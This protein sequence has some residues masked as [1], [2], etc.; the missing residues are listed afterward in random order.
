MVAMM[1]LYNMAVVALLAMTPLFLMTVHGLSPAATG[2]AFS[3]MVLVGALSQPFV[4]RLSDRVGRRPVFVAGNAVA[5]L[6]AVGIALA[7]GPWLAIAAIV[8][9]ATVLVGIRSVVLAAAV[10][11]SGRRESTTLG[12]AF[13]VMDGV[14][15]FGAL[16]AG[17]VGNIDL[18]YSFMLAA[19]LSALAA[20][21]ALG[22]PSTISTRCAGE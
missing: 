1:G 6:A 9:T 16:L 4:G 3:L 12:F 5:A 18:H 19:G 10:D 11:F 20:A 15:A 8:V 13:A 21:I 17:A 22:A 7:P 14:G 2:I